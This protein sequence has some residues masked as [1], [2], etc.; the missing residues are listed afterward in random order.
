MTPTRMR[1]RA[2]SLRS[3]MKFLAH[4]CFYCR[5]SREQDPS[6]YFWQLLCMAVIC[7]PYF[8]FCFSLSHHSKLQ[9]NLTHSTKKSTLNSLEIWNTVKEEEAPVT[10]TWPEDSFLVQSC[11]HASLETTCFLQAFPN[12]RQRSLDNTKKRML[13]PGYHGQPNRMWKDGGS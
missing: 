9:N 6:Y 4:L 2:K 7:V 11:L 1:N 12:Q 13:T 10:V 3:L 8:R 5:L